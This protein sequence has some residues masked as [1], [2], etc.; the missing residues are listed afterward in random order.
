MPDDPTSA[1]VASDKSL[2]LDELDEKFAAFQVFCK[3]DTAAADKLLGNLG[4]QDDADRD[5]VLE[6]SAARPLGHPE[7]LNTPTP[8]QY[9]PSKCSALLPWL[10]LPIALLLSA[11]SEWLTDDESAR[12]EAWRL[13]RLAL[14]PLALPGLRRLA[15]RWDLRS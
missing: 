4:A 6:L 8:S 3:S 10:L 5:I 12:L 14:F 13:S 1:D 15:A 7:R 2:L 9:V 11:V